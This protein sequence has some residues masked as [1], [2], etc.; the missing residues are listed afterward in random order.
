MSNSINRLCKCAEW[1]PNVSKIN[2]VLSLHT[3]RTGWQ[4]DG[5]RFKFCPWCGSELLFVPLT[6]GD[7]LP[8]PSP[9]T[10]E[11]L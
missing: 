5:V 10:K 9:E 7:L 4:Y 8:R 2:S 11:S 3:V 6:V 1:E